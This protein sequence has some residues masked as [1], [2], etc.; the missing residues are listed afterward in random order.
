MELTIVPKDVEAKREELS[1]PL[2][3]LKW[4]VE[5]AYLDWD[6]LPRHDH[7][8]WLTGLIAFIEPGMGIWMAS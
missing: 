5:F 4:C 3:Q 6:S 8:S 7:I 1:L 2:A